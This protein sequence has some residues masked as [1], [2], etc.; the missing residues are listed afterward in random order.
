LLPGRYFHIVFT[1]PGLLRPLFYINQPICY[2]ILFHS[3]REALLKVGKN[4]C[5]LGAEVGA[6]AVLHTWGQNLDYHPHIHMLVPAGGLSEDGTEWV[7][8][9]KKY[10]APQKAL[11]AIFRGIMVKK[12]GEEMSKAS[13]VLPEK[14]PDFIIIK[15]QLYQKD[16][17]VKSKRAFGGINSVLVYLGRYT[18]RVA[19]S[20][21]RLISLENG[22]VKF[23]FKNYRNH[24]LKGTMELDVVE[25]ARRF[26]QHILP[27]GFYKIR[28]VGILATKHIHGKREMAIA[29]LGKT[30]WLPVLEGL[31][32]Y[33]VARVLTG[34]EP[35]L[36]PVCKIGVM[37]TDI[38]PVQRE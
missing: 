35:L 12:I 16:W 15:Q 18:H 32:A 29:L 26:L 8:A 28:Y 2:D 38:T 37:T 3:A 5:F 17:N 33:E 9:P 6:V 19:I 1:L 25:F 30:M 23:S 11:A 20:N 36:C 22:K 31:N 7:A 27:L 21:S 24:G 4:P 10:F 14:F 13:L 34:E